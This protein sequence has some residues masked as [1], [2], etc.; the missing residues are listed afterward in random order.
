MRHSSKIRFLLTS[1]VEKAALKR[2]DFVF[3]V[4]GYMRAHFEKKYKL[5]FQ[6]HFY[7]MPCL[8]DSFHA[9]TFEEANK[10]INN[11]FCYVGTTAVWQC[12]DETIALYSQIERKIEGAKLLLL[13]KDKELAEKTLEKYHVN[14]Y[15]IDFVSV[16]QLPV[17]LKGVKYGFI[18]RKPSV[19]N[20]VATPTKT[21]TYISSGVIPIYSSCLNG[22]SEIFRECNYKV[23]VQ[24]GNELDSILKA[25]KKPISNTEILEEYRRIYH[26]FYDADTHIERIATKFRKIGLV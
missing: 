23:E 10:Y 12:F 8:N 5:S 18:L 26:E 9:E 15:E 24:E 1:A 22:I 16:D 25:I 2:A 4:S 14:N 11:I 19:V 17:R 6:D 13:V 3:F 20:A 21:L 7:L